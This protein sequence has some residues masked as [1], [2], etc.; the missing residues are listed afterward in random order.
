MTQPE[1]NIVK[2][3]QKQQILLSAPELGIALDYSC[4]KLMSYFS[5]SINANNKDEGKGAISFTSS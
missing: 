4:N 5:H 3:F 1:V 2:C